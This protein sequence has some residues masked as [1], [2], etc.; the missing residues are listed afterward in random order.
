M[1][2]SCLYRMG[3]SKAFK[4]Y[5]LRTSALTHTKMKM[6]NSTKRGAK[7]NTKRNSLDFRVLLLQPMFV[8]C[9]P[10]VPRIHLAIFVLNL[11]AWNFSNREME[12]T[13]IFYR[14]KFIDERRACVKLYVC[15][16][17]AHRVFLSVCA[18]V[19]T[20]CCNGERQFLAC[21]TQLPDLDQSRND[22]QIE[23]SETDR[24]SPLPDSIRATLLC[25]THEMQISETI[26]TSTWL[27]QYRVYVWLRAREF[28]RA[29]RHNTT[30]IY[31]EM[32]NY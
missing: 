9:L 16:W 32:G 27:Q 5:H 29:T 28:A 2:V 19:G 24:S 13:A 1:G 12:M 21:E 23:S 4:R 25:E 18:G 10:F 7:Q 6:K 31:Y 3:A 11:C 26:S 15:W 8:G 17:H 30:R 22:N 14:I 20:R